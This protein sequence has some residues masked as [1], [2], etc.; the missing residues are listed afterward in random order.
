MPAAV[1]PTDDVVLAVHG[2]AGPVPGGRLGA[3]RERASRAGLERALRAGQDALAEGATAL[4]A[5]VAAVAVLEDD[6]TFNAGRGAVYTTDATQELEAA[7]MT[8][9]DREAGAVAGLRHVRNPVRA[10]RLVH[11][12][13]QH[14]L[15]AGPPAEDLA[16]QHGLELVPAAWFHAPDRLAALLADAGV[17]DATGPASPTEAAASAPA[18]HDAPGAGGFRGDRAP[19]GGTVGA[20][21]RGPEGELAA[22]TST[23]GMTGKA[24]GRIGDTPLIGAGTYA[25][26]RVA[27]SATGTGERFVRAVAAHQVAALVA[28]A[29]CT[30]DEAAAAVVDDVAALGGQGGLLA[31]TGEGRLAWPFGTDLMHRGSLTAGGDLGVALY[32]PD[33]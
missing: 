27:V 29:G 32:D 28:H 9:H 33:A 13:S 10:A 19:E 23:G 16:R 17:V 11:E 3:E 14:V 2:G 24:P 5:A 8:G 25:D 12:G 30:V 18:D 7:V 4:D 6:A 31:L 15:L 22:A 26:G 21:A 1:P 20:V